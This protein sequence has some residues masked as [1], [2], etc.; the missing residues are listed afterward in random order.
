M[1]E[2]ILSVDFFSNSNIITTV[3]CRSLMHLRMLKTEY[4]L[5]LGTFWNLN[6][7]VINLLR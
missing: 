3:H 1:T 7:S 6:P 5:V 2:F 4:F